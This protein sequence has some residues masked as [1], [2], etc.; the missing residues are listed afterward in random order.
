MDFL[1]ILTAILKFLPAGIQLTQE[2]VALITA[3]AAMFN[4]G[5]I[6]MAQQEAV[7][8]SLAAH[9]AKH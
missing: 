3:I 6:P 7:V 9:L 2:L 5:A 4:T 1:T 8:A